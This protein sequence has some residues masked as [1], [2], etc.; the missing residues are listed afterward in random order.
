MSWV[1]P[2]PYVNE[3]VV[4]AQDIDGLNH[5]NNACY[6]VWCEEVAWQHSEYLGLS[7]EDYKSLDRCMVLHKAEYE[8]FLPSLLGDTLHF[9]TWITKC[10][11]RLRLERQFQ[12]I[13]VSTGETVMRGC[14]SLVCATYSSGKATRFPESFMAA[15][16]SKPLP[17]GR[18]EAAN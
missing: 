7:V 18:I 1:Y 12:A 15:Y 17:L 8:Y 11:R 9:A 14:W 4:A 10:D 5:A 13:K 16:G 6:V 2:S 3:I